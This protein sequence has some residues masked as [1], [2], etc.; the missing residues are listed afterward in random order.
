MNL[1]LNVWKIRIALVFIAAALLLPFLGKNQLIDWDETLYA[2]V[3][4]EML[5]TGDYSTSQMYFTPFYT[6]P[7]PPV[8]FWM[9]SAAMK[10]FGV[11]AF[12]AR[13][14]NVIC[15]ILSLLILFE[16]GRKLINS[17]F[18]ILWAAAYGCSIFPFLFFKS[19]YMDPWYHLLSFL[20]AALFAFALSETSEQKKWRFL[21]TSSILIGLAT[22][23]KGHSILVIMGLIF[24]VCFFRRK[25]QLKPHHYLFFFTIAIFVSSLWFFSEAALGRA[26]MIKAFLRYQTGLFLKDKSPGDPFYYHGIAFLFGC[27]PASVFAVHGAFS[28]TIKIKMFKEFMMI[29]FW[30]VFIFFSVSASKLPTYAGLAWFPISF[31]AALSLHQILVEKKVPKILLGGLLTVSALISIYLVGILYVHNP[32]TIMFSGENLRAAL[33]FSA[34]KQ[35]NPVW[36]RWEIIGG[37]I[38][39]VGILISAAC[40][41]AKKHL[42]AIFGIFLISLFASFFCHLVLL[43]KWLEMTQEP[44]HQFCE[45]HRGQQATAK[46]FGFNSFLVPFYM[47][48]SPETEKHRP[49]T[50]DVDEFINWKKDKPVYFIVRNDFDPQFE[51]KYPVLRSKKI[52]SS[53]RLIF[54]RLN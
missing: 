51:E 24:G 22:L 54:Y 7:K 35:V 37:I 38:F 9:Q 25:N 27:F 47:Q 1:H 8:F 48:V 26:D 46:T 33:N 41:A 16:L 34:W 40:F 29:L 13:F 11:N 52:M 30:V 10:A 49:S 19:G 42:P 36:S 45:A 4:R 31:F 23:V 39:M 15:G 17:E 5:V 32:E 53:D 20:G 2:E 3:S 28:K 18:G 14:P 21:A 50:K 6:K 12:A 44:L 43:P